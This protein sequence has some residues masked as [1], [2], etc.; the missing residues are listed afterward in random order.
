MR[1]KRQA[2]DPLG[3]L[4][5]DF[6]GDEAEAE[7]GAEAGAD[8]WTAATVEVAAVRLLARR[9]HSRKELARKLHARGVPPELVD[10]VLQGLQ[11]RRLQSDE[12]Y[13]E[14]L[15][16]SRISRG[17]GPVRIRRDLSQQG[18]PDEDIDTALE[19]AGV[20]W[21]ALA[22][23]TRVRRFGADAPAEWKERARQARFLEY[24][25]FSGDQIREALGD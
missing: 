23:E 14:S 16:N 15:V 6:E 11:A 21:Y 20:D 2:E 19:A 7:R 22:R 1:K 5:E 9:E 12:R 4:D 10:Q 17:Q 24:R 18:I 25:G 3:L 8:E 13:A